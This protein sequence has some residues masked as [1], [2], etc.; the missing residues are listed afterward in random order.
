[1]PCT[2]NAVDAQPLTVVSNRLPVELHRNREGL[3]VRPSSGGL[4]GA[5]SPILRDRGG[6]WV[7]WPGCSVDGDDWTAPLEAFAQQSGYSLEPVNLSQADI[8]AYYAGFANSVLWPLFHGFS[9]LCE[10]RPEFWKRYLDVNR[11][12]ALRLARSKEVGSHVWIH[13]YHL[14]HV[15]KML[16]TAKMD[17]ERLGFF[18]HIPFPAVDLCRRMPWMHQIVDA[19]LAYDLVGFQT[20]QD[21][22]NFLGCVA[23]CMPH[24]EIERGRTSAVLD[25][26]HRRLRAEAFPIGTDFDDFSERASRPEVA[27]RA[28][29][30]QRELGP[31][32][33]LLGVDRLDY[34]KGLIHRLEALEVALER[35][36]SL[37]E[38]VVLYQLV[39]PSREKVG[40]YASLK[41]ELE[42]TVGRI[43]GRFS[44]R[45]WSPIRYRYGRVDRVELGAMYRQA[46]A[47]LVTP[48]RDG[49][50]LVAK[51][52]VASQVDAN[53]VLVLSEFAGAAGQ[54]AD[55]ALLTNPYDT[56]ATAETIR[57]AVEMGADERASR[58]AML[59]EVVRETDVYWWAERFVDRMEQ[60][61]DKRSVAEPLW[62]T[63]SAE[64]LPLRAF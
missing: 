16:R 59:R 10:F 39:V 17:L 54:L 37:R 14:I 58:M 13:D 9:R 38:R 1:M 18:L 32:D 53:G 30:L 44:T 15:G 20:P 5:M 40:A 41:D 60:P 29:A 4:V 46:R 12:F 33:I 28:E 61:L 7:G 6:T 21:L 49:M 26:G 31:Y 56:E 2:S 24:C 55:G 22:H 64:A 50:N 57:R 3:A 45:K 43:C 47:A 48:L 27:A 34:T 19:L 23:H 51:E 35:Y 42:R 63:P 11:R 62:R 25:V 52:Y 8:D 36:P